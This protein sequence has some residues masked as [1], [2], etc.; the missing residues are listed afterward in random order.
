[1][2][3]ASVVLALLFLPVEANSLTPHIIIWALPLFTVA[4]IFIDVTV[5]ARVN[6]NLKNEKPFFPGPRAYLRAAGLAFIFWFSIGVVYALATFVYTAFTG[7]ETAQTP[8]WQIK[9]MLILG[10]VAAVWL[11][12]ATQSVVIN[13]KKIFPAAKEGAIFCLKGIKMFLFILIFYAVMALA[14]KY[15]DFPPDMKAQTDFL[16]FIATIASRAFRYCFA[17]AA[18]IAMFFTL[19]KRVSPE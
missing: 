8:A 17:Y 9:S 3:A 18:C 15:A 13:Q 10:P 6:A 4:S 12:M 7:V 16:Q 1:M 14:Q 2:I 11:A 5:F 19:N